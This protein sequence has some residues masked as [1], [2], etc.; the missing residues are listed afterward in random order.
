[1]TF[2][3]NKVT[4]PTL[5]TLVIACRPWTFQL[6][7]YQS[8]A[9]KMKTYLELKEQ[10]VDPP[11]PS[12]TYPERPDTPS[13]QIAQASR[14]KVVKGSKRTSKNHQTDKR[15]LMA[16]L[17]KKSLVLPQV[18]V[19]LIPSTAVTTTTTTPPMISNLLSATTPWSSTFPASKTNLSP[20]HDQFLLTEKKTPCQFQ[21][22]RE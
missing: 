9:R 8:L 19:T 5:P 21:Q 10:V 18:S 22:K 1:M 3:G 6:H 2:S 17:I 15:Q 16:R 14:S 11:H 7:P 13:P 12:P 4:L 20:D